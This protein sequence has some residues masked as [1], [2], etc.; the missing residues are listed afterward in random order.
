M[1]MLENYFQNEKKTLLPKL[2]QIIDNSGMGSS[3]VNSIQWYIKQANKQM[4]TEGRLEIDI[5]EA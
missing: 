5:E 2:N 1:E 4:V 3:V